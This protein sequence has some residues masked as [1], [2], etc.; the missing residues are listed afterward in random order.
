MKLYLAI[1]LALGA[2]SVSAQT[3]YSAPRLADGKPDLNGIWQAQGKADAD[4]EG[5]I[6]GKNIIVDPAGGRMSE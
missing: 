5:K 3:K 6:G 1:A 2:V 4:I